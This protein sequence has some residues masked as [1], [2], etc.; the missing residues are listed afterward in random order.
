VLPRGSVLLWKGF[1]E[2]KGL[3]E[4]SED[5]P[6]REIKNHVDREL[7]AAEFFSADRFWKV[8]EKLAQ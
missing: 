4:W 8:V 6:G 7:E 1:E 3:V 2:L 5:Y